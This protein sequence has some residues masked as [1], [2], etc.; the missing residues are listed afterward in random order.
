VIGT[1][2][3]RM[4]NETYLHLHLVAP[5][6]MVLQS[7]NAG[8]PHERLSGTLHFIATGR[9]YEDLKFSAAISAKYLGV[10]VPETCA[11]IY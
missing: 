10:I 9:S 11:A 3:L 4:G 1:I 8:T 5:H 6:I 2:I 7:D